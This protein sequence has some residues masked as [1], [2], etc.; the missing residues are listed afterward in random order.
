MN[1]FERVRAQL[2]AFAS[3]SL[4]ID[5]PEDAVNDAIAAAI[6][7]APHVRTDPDA[8]LPEAKARLEQYSKD[9]HWKRRRGRS[10]PLNEDSVSE[11][12]QQP[13]RRQ[14]KARF[15][16]G[17]ATYRSADIGEVAIGSG[18]GDTADDATR[19]AAEHLGH[20]DLLRISTGEPCSLKAARLIRELYRE[21]KGV[22]PAH[23]WAFLLVE[24]LDRAKRQVLSNP[25]ATSDLTTS[26]SVTLKRRNVDNDKPVRKPAFIV[27]TPT[28]RGRYMRQAYIKESDQAKLIATTVGTTDPEFQYSSDRLTRAGEILCQV[29][30]KLAG[31]TFVP[32]EIPA[33]ADDPQ[34]VAWLYERLGFEGGGG[35][36]SVKTKKLKEW[37]TNPSLLA[38]ALERH[39]ARAC[40][41][42]DEAGAEALQEW[43]APVVAKIRKSATSEAETGRPVKR[44][45]D[46]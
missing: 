32:Q 16:A 40:E 12:G 37:L 45:E 36:S 24:E 17:L 41:R 8:L 23:H 10:E 13:V 43:A 1:P 4:G 14:R 44:L 15:P 20:Q 31:E 25:E 39:V 21:L 7:A 18:V 2:L 38:D 46:Q 3:Q 35:T 29:R 9:Q 30:L 33:F 27:E 11:R 26:S 19:R 28:T 6:A 42:L 5:A 34:L 22:Y